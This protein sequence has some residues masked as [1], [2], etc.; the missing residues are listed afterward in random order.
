MCA[1]GILLCDVDQAG[2]GLQY[3][4]QAITT[5]TGLTQQR[6]EGAAFWDLFTLV[7]SRGAGSDEEVQQAVA[8]GQP[9]TLTCRLQAAYSVTAGWALASGRLSGSSEAGAGAGSTRGS[10]DCSSSIRGPGAFVVTLTPASSPDFRP[11]EM[12]IGLPAFA[13]TS[14]CGAAGACERYWFATVQPMKVHVTSSSQLSSSTA[15]GSGS[16]S[17][18]TAAAAAAA[19]S[20]FD[21][22]RPQEMEG[23]QLGPLLGV[24]ASGRC[25]GIC[26]LL[27]PLL[28]PLLR[29]LA[30]LLRLRVIPAARHWGP[31]N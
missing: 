13:S 14:N 21:R 29:P 5:L 25:V 16:G 8:K 11:D 7:P 24:G 10:L 6:T 17:G 28:M 22:M 31:K 9:F 18:G 30:P 15:S 2:W 26:L 1:E 12:P 4:N 3:S 19:A 27:M 20:S 23:V